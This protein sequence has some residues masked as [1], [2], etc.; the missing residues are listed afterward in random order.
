MNI[1]ATATF[2][3]GTQAEDMGDRDVRITVLFSTVLLII[4][5][6]QRF[7]VTSVRTGLLISAFLL[8]SIPMWNLFK[9]WHAQ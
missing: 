7:R 4:A 9:L 5:I 3:R 8:L 1:E 2:E 6:G